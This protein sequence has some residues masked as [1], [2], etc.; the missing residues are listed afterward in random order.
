[1]LTREEWGE[2]AK[3]FYKDYKDKPEGEAKDFAYQQGKAFAR[4]LIERMGIEG[5]DVKAIAAVL[6][7]VLKYEPTA[8]VEI[9]GDKVH[10]I[11]E[12]FC[13]VME[14]SLALNLPWEKMCKIMGWPFFLGLAHAVN[15]E[16]VFIAP[17]E[18][19]WRLKGDPYCFHIFEI[20]RK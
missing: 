14:T 19:K 17:E 5:D 1:M 3:K 13:P 7:A 20:R 12:G 9:H 4:T 16:A 18:L 10:L 2:Y 6:G 8:K 15:P 11:N